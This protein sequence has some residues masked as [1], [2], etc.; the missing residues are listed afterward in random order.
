MGVVMRSRPKLRRGLAY[1]EAV[2]A[3]VV[4]AICLSGLGATMVAQEKLMRAVERRVYVLSPI[5]CDVQLDLSS[6][7]VVATADDG[8]LEPLDDVEA[9]TR[10]HVDKLGA[11]S[12]RLMSA[13]DAR[14]DLWPSGGRWIGRPLL[15]TT[16]MGNDGSV[17]E[18]FDLAYDVAQVDDPYLGD[19]DSEMTVT[20]A[21]SP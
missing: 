6:G 1:T 12:R 20:M 8:S 15:V 4:F 16:G 5:R 19:G 9:L 2:T 11:P 21:A 7:V 18:E 3:S 17:P 14:V 10:Y 13:V